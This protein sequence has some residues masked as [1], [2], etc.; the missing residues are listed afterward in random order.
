M[1]ILGSK[2]TW[3]DITAKQSAEDALDIAAEIDDGELRDLLV[4]HALSIS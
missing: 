4:R 1:F 3:P 2:D